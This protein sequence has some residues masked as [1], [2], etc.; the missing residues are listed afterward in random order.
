MFFPTRRSG[1]VA[2]KVN[3]AYMKTVV[4]LKIGNVTTV[5]QY[6]A[7]SLHLNA[8]RILLHQAAVLANVAADF[9]HGA[10]VSV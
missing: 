4:M 9:A 5:V 6:C 3:H 10:V 1:L 7:A 2:F 8:Q